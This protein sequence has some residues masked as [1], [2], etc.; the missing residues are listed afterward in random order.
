MGRGLMR[1]RYGTVVVPDSLGAYR[2]QLDKAP[3]S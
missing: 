3:E 1:T 2:L